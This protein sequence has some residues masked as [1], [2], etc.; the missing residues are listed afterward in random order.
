[1]NGISQTMNGRRMRSLTA[2]L[3]MTLAAGPALAQTQAHRGTI[4]TRDRSLTG[5]IRWRAASREYSIEAA[6]RT[7]NIPPRDVVNIVLAQPPAQLEQAVRA[8]Q[9][10]Q[11]AQAVPVLRQIMN[12]YVMLGPDRIAGR[13]L[14]QAYLDMGQAGEA[15]KAVDELLRSSPTANQNAELMGIYVDALIKNNELARA[16][17]ALGD[18][19]ASGSRGAAAMA[20]VKRGD[21]QMQRGDMRE[22]LISGFLRTIVLFQDVREV[23]PEALY[24]AI[25]CHTAL[26]EHHY[27]E[28]WRKRLL[29]G[30][31]N[32]E[33]ARK[34][35]RE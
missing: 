31:P 30:F 14:A 17:R 5:D 29:S 20:Q 24:K 19:V 16:E 8:V 18:I 7:L 33:Y 9:A 32:S 34:L 6:G 15:I 1:M 28:R 12:A 26:N 11:G 22:A 13:Y 27:A 4:Q 35:S 3:V 25:E 21:I 2:A 10:G 23:Q